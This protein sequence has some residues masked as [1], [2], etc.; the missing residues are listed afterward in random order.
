MGVDGISATGCKAGLDSVTYLQ[1]QRYTIAFHLAVTVKRGTF[2]WAAQQEMRAAVI[3]LDA[4]Q[5]NDTVVAGEPVG[6]H[7]LQP[8]WQIR[9]PLAVRCMNH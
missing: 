8:A 4:P 2:F 5:Y 3:V 9:R 6:V 1:S 7:L